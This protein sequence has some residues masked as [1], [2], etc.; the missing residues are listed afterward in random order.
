MKKHLTLTL[1]LALSGCIPLPPTDQPEELPLHDSEAPVIVETGSLLPAEQ[2]LPTGILELGSDTAPLTLFLFTEHD[3]AY[4]KEF[5]KE[6]LP[7]LLA[8][9]VSTNKLRLQIIPFVLQKYEYSE[10][11]AVEALCAT[12]QGKG[13]QMHNALF[14]DKPYNDLEL[15][16]E[17]F[18]NCLQT[19]ESV[20]LVQKQQ[21]WAKDM[22]VQFVPSILLNDELL[23]GLPYYADIRGR[24]DEA[25]STH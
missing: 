4:C 2:A 1:T 24:I 14:D 9:Y 13:L 5:H 7:L 19:P 15:D 12:A 17:R 10:R 16:E 22:G 18:T 20:D 6:Q 25:L 11:R 21:Q 3:C 23:E 8:Q